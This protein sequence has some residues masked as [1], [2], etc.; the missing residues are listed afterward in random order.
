MR[1]V[2]KRGGCLVSLLAVFVTGGGH[3]MA[4]QSVA[5]ARMLVAYS[6]Q[7]SLVT[8][9]EQTFDGDHPCP[10]CKKISQDRAQE[11]QE[12]PQ[13]P[14]SSGRVAPETMCL[15]A[16]AS[17]PPVPVCHWFRRA[18]APAA[19]RDIVLTPPTPPPRA[20]RLSA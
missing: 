1:K 5:W 14:A 13:G 19:P 20:P 16:G 7:S 4:L 6:Q 10:M 15:T 9:V 3:W 2:L 11:R 18:V 12:Q 17:I 8:A